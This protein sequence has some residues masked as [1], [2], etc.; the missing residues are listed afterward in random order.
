[1]NWVI[2][3]Y[4]KKGIHVLIIIKER[5][6]EQWENYYKLVKNLAAVV[7]A[8]NSST[9]EAETGLWDT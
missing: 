8:F 2:G 6:R 9:R 7:Y 5:L 1:M 3:F 4:G